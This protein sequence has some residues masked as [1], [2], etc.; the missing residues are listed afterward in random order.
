MALSGVDLALWDLRGKAAGVPVAKL[1]NPQVDLSRR[2][3]TYC[4]VWSE[5]DVASAIE[6]GHGAVKLHVESVVRTSVRTPANQPRAVAAKATAA[7]DSHVDVDT[8]VAAVRRVRESLG[9]DQALMVD[10]F[11]HW[12]VPST[13][14]IA[15]QLAPLNVDW[16]EEPLP[17]DD[18]DGYA[19]LAAGSPVPIAGGEH[20]YLAEGFRHLIKHRLHAVLQPDINWCGGLTTLAEIYQMAKEAGLRVCPHRGSEA[21]ALHAIAALD[22]QPLAESPRK[23]FTCL[24][25]APR[26]DGGKVHVPNAPGFGVWID[27]ALWQ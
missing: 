14:R 27:D 1:L 7:V 20:E 26:I 10:A 15:E 22:P 24:K 11:A 16:L 13:L 21:F 4:T 19:Q 18:E 3:D 8:V 25:G 2:I 23:W 9:A 6:S 5:A 17:P 12:D